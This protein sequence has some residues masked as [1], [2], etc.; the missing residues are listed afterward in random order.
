LAASK[1]ASS[2]A[3]AADQFDQLHQ[4]HRIHEVN[5]D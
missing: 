3:M 4:R 2:V 1:V 5:A